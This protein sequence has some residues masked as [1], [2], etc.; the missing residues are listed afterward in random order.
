[1]TASLLVLLLVAHCTSLDA[2]SSFAL[3]PLP[4]AFSTAC[5]VVGRRGGQQS[6]PMLRRC[7]EATRQRSTARFASD[8]RWV[9]VGRDAEEEDAAGRRHVAFDTP[10][11]IVRDAS[12]LFGEVERGNST[13]R[14]GLRS[15]FQEFETPESEEESE[16]WRQSWR[17]AKPQETLYVEGHPR[18]RWVP[19]RIPLSLSQVFHLLDE[20]AVSRALKDPQQRNYWIYHTGRTLFFFLSNVLA[21]LLQMKVEPDW[22]PWVYGKNYRRELAAALK[23]IAMSGEKKSSGE[24]ASAT[25]IPS[26]ERVGRLFGS[27]FE[28]YR[29]DCMNIVYGIYR[30][31]YDASLRHRQFNP[32]YVRQRFVDTLNEAILMGSRRAKGEGGKREVRRQVLLREAQALGGV[33]IVNDPLRED[34]DLFNDRYL[35]GDLSQYPDYYLQNFHW[36]TDGWL[37]TRSARTYEYTTESL[38]SG[39]QDAMQRQSFVSI[40]EHIS[41]LKGIKEEHEMKLLE[42]ACGTGRWHT[43]IKDNWPGIQSVASDLSPYYLQVAEENML[44]FAEFTR[45][46]TGRE[47]AWPKFVQAKAEDLPFEDEE[48]DIVACTYLFHEIPF[49]VRKEV[50]SEMFRVLEPGGIAVITDSFQKGDIPERDHIGKRFPANYHEPFYMSYFENTD[51]VKIYQQAGFRLRTHQCAHLSKVLTFEKPGGSHSKI[52]PYALWAIV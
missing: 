20:P 47:I 35:L 52:R 44:Y 22:R 25:K 4:C 17:H 42:V 18:D 19:M 8:P 28:L 6:E 37:S 38:F 30:Y 33:V 40:S 9:D 29:R 1:M 51:L 41:L 5:P 10:P 16:Q 11:V 14:R 32:V 15:R 21:A 43:F 12:R 7:H 3:P 49:P 13:G 45:A 31:P 50:A 39:S 2:F 23:R 27:I 34:E 36:Q 48:F 46:V 24:F 26:A